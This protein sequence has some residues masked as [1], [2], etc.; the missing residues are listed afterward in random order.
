MIAPIK[1]D[2]LT[3]AD[4]ADLATPT[5]QATP[6]LFQRAVFERLTDGGWEQKPLTLDQ[7]QRDELLNLLA[8]WIAQADLSDG[9]GEARLMQARLPLRRLAHACGVRSADL[10]GYALGMDAT[11]SLFDLSVEQ[12]HKLALLG[13]A[14]FYRGFSLAQWAEREPRLAMLFAAAAVDDTALEAPHAAAMRGLLADLSELPLAD[15]PPVALNLLHRA[16]FMLGYQPSAHRYRAKQRL[17]EQAARMLAQLPLPQTLKPALRPS[18]ERPRL[19]V[20]AEKLVPGHAFYRFF[21]DLIQQLRS[22]FEVVLYAEIETRCDAHRELSHSQR[23]FRPSTTPLAGWIEDVR[24]LQPDLIFYP[25]IGMSF[26]TFSLSLLR[27]APLQVASSGHPSPSCSAQIDA[28]LLFDGLPIPTI[29]ALP[30]PLYYHQHR[31]LPAR[32]QA[33]ATVVHA[34]PPISPVRTIGINAMASKLN[35]NF[36]DMIQQIRANCSVP[37]RLLMFPNVGGLEH[38]G[39]QARLLALLGDVEVIPTTH[40]AAYLDRLAECDIILQSFPFGGANTT[41]DGLKLGIPVVCLRGD[42]LSGLIDPM[43]LALYDAE[44]WCANDLIAYAET[45]IGLLRDP[46]IAAN[47]RRRLDQPERQPATAAI[48]G[49][50]PGAALHAHWL[51]S[52]VAAGE[53]S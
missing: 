23:Y 12:R 15:L 10:L 33:S 51:A 38:Q 44:A 34:S 20:I 21:A 36:L 40:H 6:A 11:F 42:S 3:S 5:M 31:L 30:M 32:E 29:G 50:A 28:T 46:H 39:L 9:E 1:G 35:A 53:P 47:R 2:G 18:R 24:M 45:A 14:S 49:M 26:L 17:A 43:L 7:A 25:S 37:T 48:G 22:H 8:R 52:T 16:C 27:L 13:D 4:L 41:I 19:L